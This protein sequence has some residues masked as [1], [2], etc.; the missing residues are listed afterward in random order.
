MAI[1]YSRDFKKLD[2]V[3][4]FLRDNARKSHLFDSL[5]FGNNFSDILKQVWLDFLE[6]KKK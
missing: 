2:L 6:N 3:R 1:D 4:S 5:V